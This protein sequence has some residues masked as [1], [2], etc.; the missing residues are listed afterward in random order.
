VVSNSVRATSLLIR[1]P[2]PA[3][4]ARDARVLA[5]KK[6]DGHVGRLRLA[7]IEQEILRAGFRH[8]RACKFRYDCKH[9]IHLRHRRARSRHRP[10][11]DDDLLGDQLDVG[12]AFAKDVRE[13]PCRRRAPPV[14]QARLRKH[15][16]AGAGGRN[17]R[18][19][20]T[21]VSDE[22]HRTPNRRA[23]QPPQQLGS[24]FG[25]DTRHD[26]QVAGAEA[27]ACRSRDL[28]PVQSERLPPAGA[29]PH[30]VGRGERIHRD[31]EAR[32]H[33]VREIHHHRAR[34]CPDIPE[35]C[36]IRH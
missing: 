36:R 6:R 11:G 21:R 25:I 12:K 2:D 24:G 35:R 22:T 31:R 1:L 3:L 33:A 10:V 20:R 26:Q 8:F 16:R 19:C 14:E 13:P 5:G 9:Q 7:M 30:G 4:G 28:Q 18:A 29:P 15:E 27:E 23:S 34:H 32:R 17:G